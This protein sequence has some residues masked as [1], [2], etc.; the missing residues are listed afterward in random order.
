[1]RAVAPTGMAGTGP[2]MSYLALLPLSCSG[3]I[4]CC[5]WRCSCAPEPCEEQKCSRFDGM[6]CWA[7]S[8]DWNQLQ[9]LVY[10][11]PL[12]NT[13]G[14][15]GGLPKQTEQA[16]ISLGK[17]IQKWNFPGC[18][19]TLKGQRLEKFKAGG[20]EGHP[21]HAQGQ[22]TMTQELSWSTSTLTQSSA[23]AKE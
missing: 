22:G 4:G 3:S 12:G 16:T 19:V 21:S 7:S 10:A 1:M 11:L 18:L 2:S 6:G 17:I 20:R 13:A 15:A 9:Q 14:Q 23:L 5:T 8:S